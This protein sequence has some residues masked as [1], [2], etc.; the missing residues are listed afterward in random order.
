MSRVTFYIFLECCNG[1]GAALDAPHEVL[2]SSTSS[3]MLIP[4]PISFWDV[5]PEHPAYKMVEFVTGG[6]FLLENSS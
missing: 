2:P 1:G 6:N 4:L 5:L 3:V